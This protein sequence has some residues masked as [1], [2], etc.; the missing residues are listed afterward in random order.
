MT[1]AKYNFLLQLILNNSSLDSNGR[2]DLNYSLDGMVDIF[3]KTFESEI[4]GEWKQ[5]KLE[6]NKED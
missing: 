2:I 1:D 5:V 3:L 4:Y 6:E